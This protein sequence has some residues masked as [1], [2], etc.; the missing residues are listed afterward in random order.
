MS[1]KRFPSPRNRAA[2]LCAPLVLLLIQRAGAAGIEWVSIAGYP[3]LTLTR[4]VLTPTFTNAGGLLAGGSLAILDLET[5]GTNVVIQGIVNGSPQ[6]VS[7]SVAQYDVSN[8]NVLAAP[9][10]PLTSTLTAPGDRRSTGAS[11]AAARW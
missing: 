3:P 5:T 10:N 1:R 4:T 9:W 7:W 6:S 8:S 11:G 2:L